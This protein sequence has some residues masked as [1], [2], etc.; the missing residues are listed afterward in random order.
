MADAPH[1]PFVRGNLVCA[2]LRLERSDEALRE[3]APLR[4][5]QPFN[6]DWIAYEEMALRQMGDP[7]SREICDYD[8]M[9]QPFDL[10][11]PNGYANMAEF[12]AALKESL[13][14]LHVLETHPLDQSLRHG[15]QT[16][17]SLLAVDDPVI[18][19]Y[20]QAL[21]SADPAHT[22]PRCKSRIIHGADARS[23]HF[24]VFGLLVGEAE[25][26]TAIT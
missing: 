4:R 26:R 23:E 21:R 1:V 20:L 14:R 24:E 3:L 17:R 2:L 10:G 25:S 22:S 5:A 16:T 15:S 19:L 8:L 12:N 6:G 11:A 7:R 18:K 9:V 13:Q